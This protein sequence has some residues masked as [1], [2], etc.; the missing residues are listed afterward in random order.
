VCHVEFLGHP[1]FTAPLDLAAIGTI[2]QAYI[3]DRK[4]RS[5]MVE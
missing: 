2:I 4:T 3:S 5:L 1:I